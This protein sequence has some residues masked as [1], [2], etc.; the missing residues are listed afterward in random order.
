MEKEW[1]LQ[2]Q[3]LQG[4]LI[5]FKE[6][7]RETAND[8]VKE[9]FSSYPIFIAHQS[10]VKIGEVILEG[11]ELATNWSISASTMEE[12]VEKGLIEKSKT[13]FFQENYKDP[14]E[15]F[16]LFV[17]YQASARFVFVPYKGKADFSNN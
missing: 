2:L 1:E 17:I 16:C 8:I 6:S 12:F 9:G 3:Q 11:A 10:P 15:Y 7:I 4:E 14:K 13:G 5:L